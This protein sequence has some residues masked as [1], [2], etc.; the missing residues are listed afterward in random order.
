M[1]RKGLT[2]VLS[3]PT[4]VYTKDP[5]TTTWSIPYREVQTAQ[6]LVQWGGQLNPRHVS[7]LPFPPTLKKRPLGA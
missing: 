6:A 2:P 4:S 5:H 3:L 1:S 7:S